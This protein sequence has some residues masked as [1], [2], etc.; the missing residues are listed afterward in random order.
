MVAR[1]TRPALQTGVHTHGASVS[2]GLSDA[3]Y[4]I[5]TAGSSKRGTLRTKL[6]TMWPRTRGTCPDEPF[7]GPVPQTCPHQNGRGAAQTGLRTD[8][9]LHRVTNVSIHRSKDVLR[10]R[11]ELRTIQTFHRKTR[12][13]SHR[14]ENALRSRSELRTNQSL[15]REAS[16]S[17]HRSTNALRSGSELRTTQSHHRKTRQPK[18]GC[19]GLLIHLS[20][21][22]QTGP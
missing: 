8:R 1:L 14:S 12:T 15:P 4:G 22:A 9:T 3:R 5:V 10:S 11:S 16:M 20:N 2:S 17:N 19:E 7:T 13:S 18:R 21:A 6:R